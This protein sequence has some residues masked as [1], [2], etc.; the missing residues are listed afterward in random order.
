[1]GIQRSEFISR[2]TA[3]TIS[4]N[5][6]INDIMKRISNQRVQPTIEQRNS[7]ERI[8]NEEEIN[9]ADISNAVST[10]SRGV[11]NYLTN[12]HNLEDYFFRLIS[13]A[14]DSED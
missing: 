6:N 13:R 10:A 7:I 4:P 9:A 14:K 2:S 3:G 12:L 5:M 8:A 11:G 1:M